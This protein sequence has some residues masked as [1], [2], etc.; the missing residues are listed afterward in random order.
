MGASTNTPAGQRA[1]VSA[2]KRH[3]QDT[4]GTLDQAAVMRARV[5][6]RR[7]CPRRGIRASRSSRVAGLAPRWRRCRP[8]RR[9][10]GRV[11]DGRRVS[12]GA[13][14]PLAPLAGLT[15]LLSPGQR[16]ANRG[17]IRRR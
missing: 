14:V 15:S 3:L 4:T 16:L 8:C 1:L 5:R 10:P 12:D 9:C 13:G 17:P 6:R 11:A 2:I 7:M